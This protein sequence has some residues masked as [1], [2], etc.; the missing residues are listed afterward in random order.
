M[1]RW[2]TEDFQ[3]TETSLCDIIVIVACHY[4]SVQAIG[5]TPPTVSPNINYEFCVIIMC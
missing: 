2:S 5:C 4:T 1:N 3:G